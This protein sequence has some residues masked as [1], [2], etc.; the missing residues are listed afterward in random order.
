[1]PSETT[2]SIPQSGLDVILDKLCSVTLPHAAKVDGIGLGKEA[3]YWIF[4]E[5]ACR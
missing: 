1:M 3:K 5:G 2:E 4:P